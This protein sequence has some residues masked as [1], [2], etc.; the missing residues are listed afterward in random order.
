MTVKAPIAGTRSSPSP[1]PG[2]QSEKGIL[3]TRR[4]LRLVRRRNAIVEAHLVL[5]GG[6]RATHWFTY[7]EKSAYLTEGIDGE[8]YETTAREFAKTY[9]WAG[10]GAIW[11]LDS[12]SG[13]ARTIRQRRK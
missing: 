11:H 4:L 3:S 10:T 1:A 2:T 12:V 7:Q 13:P 6:L 5:N 9:A 8:E